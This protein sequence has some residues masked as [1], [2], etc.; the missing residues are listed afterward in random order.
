[1]YF[2]DQVPDL[3]GAIDLAKTQDELLILHND[4]HLDRCQRSLEAAAGGGVQ[5]RASCDAEP[6][7]QD[8]RPG[9]GGG[10]SIPGALPAQIAYSPPPEPSI[11][12]LDSLSGNVYH[13]SMRLVYQG[14]YQ[15]ISEFETPP[16]SLAFGPPNTLF[17]GMGDQV[18]YAQAGR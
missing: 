11:F 1:L 5:V 18:Y 8:E 17:L 15:P 16:S 3:S 7:F 6:R 4:G 2:V 9:Y 10:R 12:I 13:Y 14:Q